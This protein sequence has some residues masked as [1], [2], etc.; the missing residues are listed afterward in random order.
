M[1][2]SKYVSERTN[3][4]IGR[5]INVF[6]CLLMFVLDSYY[7]IFTIIIVFVISVHFYYY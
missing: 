3:D 1:P 4:R 5:K 6:Y 2:R 7:F